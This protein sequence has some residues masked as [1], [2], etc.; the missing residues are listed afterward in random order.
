MKPIYK[1]QNQERMVNTLALEA[2]RQEAL[3][4]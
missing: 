2:E 4:Q 3:R 1:I